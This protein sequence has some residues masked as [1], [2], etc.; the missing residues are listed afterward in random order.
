[1]M[2]LKGRQIMSESGTGMVLEH[3][4]GSGEV[5]V[6]SETRLTQFR[7]RDWDVTP[8]PEVGMPCTYSVG[9][10]SY[11]GTVIAVSPGLHKVTVQDVK[12]TRTDSNGLSE[13]QSYTYAENPEGPTRTFRLNKH[14]R[15]RAGSY[16]L[17]LGERR[18]YRD[19]S[20]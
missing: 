9:S 19:P 2:N 8:I 11:A 13:D 5:L 17:H 14:Y 4:Q 15:Y 7:L 1:M 20:Y 6:Q 16:W 10:D 3:D 12:V 18:Y